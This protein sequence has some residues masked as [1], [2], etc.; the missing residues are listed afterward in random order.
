MSAGP[1][2]SAPTTSAPTL[3]PLP[4]DGLLARDGDLVLL[5]AAPAFEVAL[6][7]LARSEDGPALARRLAPLLTDA[8]APPL[9]ALGPAGAG[10]VLIVHGT[11]RAVVTV[12]GG[13]LVLDGRDAAT[14]VDRKLAEF[15]A[16]VRAW[17]VDPAGHDDLAIREPAPWAHLDSGCV[18]AGGLL[19]T[20]RPGGGD[21][22]PDPPEP[23][24]PE[25][26][27]LK[28]TQPAPTPPAPAQPAH[29]G[30][31]PARLDPAV[32]TR[33]AARAELRRANRAEPFH[34]VLLGDLAGKAG[35]ESA[36]AQALP[37]RPLAPQGAPQVLGV[38]CKNDHFNEPAA[39]FCA[40]CGISMVQLTLVARPGRRPP[41]GL[42]VLDDGATFRLDADY[43]LGRDPDRDAAVLAGT[44]RPLRVDDDLG[45]VSRVHAKVTLD[46]W[47]VRVVDLGS[48]N[49]THLRRDGDAWQR[50]P[51]HMPVSIRPGTHV[52]FGRRG[53]R[54][55]SHRS[56]GSEAS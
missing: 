33:A 35:G 37:E 19:L 51:P 53:F 27:R 54:Y 13:E 38:H 30:P 47:A 48:A 2:T 29:P 11:A 39:R 24:R 15:P 26:T 10:L 25:P 36:G 12:D 46:G 18:P 44:A 56:T 21:A 32:R 28:P 1:S 16:A 5:C 17:L 8:D 4:G 9:V 34:A 42:L 49:G 3:R 50:I 14:Y 7:A 43:V 31:A 52:A 22:Q 41:L 6:E 40:V 20:A 23:A 45:G 55:E